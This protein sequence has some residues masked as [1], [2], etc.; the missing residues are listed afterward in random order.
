M[1]CPVSVSLS[2]VKFLFDDLLLHSVLRCLDRRLGFA[3]ARR[4]RRC[5]FR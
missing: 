2:S 5:R 1:L 3:D 4:S